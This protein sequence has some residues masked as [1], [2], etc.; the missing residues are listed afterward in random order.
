[1]SFT[2]LYT[3]DYA[4]SYGVVILGTYT[5]NFV[6]NPAFQ[7]GMAG[8]NP[9]NGASISLDSTNTIFGPSSLLVLCPGAVAGEGVTTASGVVTDNSTGSVSC[10][11]NGTGSVTVTAVDNGIV[12][13]TAHVTL[14]QQWTRIVI[15][16]LP[17]SA[18]DSVNLAIETTIA[19]P[20][21]FWLSGVQVE[22]TSP[23]HPYI[24]GNQVGGTWVSG[25]TSGVS[26]QEYENSASA[27]S[28][29][30][31][32][33]N[34]VT[35][36]ST[37]EEFFA[38]PNVSVEHTYSSLV[39]AGS[40]GPASAVTDFSVSDLTD[41]DPAQTYVSWNNAG[42]TMSSS[43]QQSWATFI[44]PAD[45]LVSDG[46]YLYRRGAFAALGWKFESAAE[47]DNAIIAR[48]QAQLLPVLTNI[49][50]PAAPVFDNPRSIHSIIVANR[51][52]FVTNPSFEVS[53]ANWTALGT[54]TLAQDS[55]VTVGDIGE[56]DDTVVTTG[57]YSL[58]ITLNANS[59]GASTS[60]TNLIPGYTYIASAYVKAGAGLDNILMEIGTG[61]TSIQSSGGTGYGASTYNT[62]P[63][64]GFNPASDIPS[65][66]WYRVWCTFTAS[67][68][69]E[70][71]EITCVQAS[72]VSYPTHMWTDAVLVEQG[73]ILNSYFDGS[74]YG[75]GYSWDSVTGSAGLAR[76]YYYEQMAVRQQA[77]N[78][79]LA[80]HTP[81][82]IGYTP[83][84]FSVPPIA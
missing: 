43:W 42:I 24:D 68:D 59:D 76:S 54:A 78:N 27:T 33:S 81:L 46:T 11:L 82:G 35:V 20:A 51:I 1:M 67:S 49:T 48:V 52:N 12:I 44:P 45:Y 31:T 73:D 56:Y 66:I 61:S 21:Q 62:G 41:P 6:I 79:V 18:G 71:L 30:K 83:P 40:S 15:T 4:S 23:A 9:V 74:S 38:V 57:S 28:Q 39:V 5:T 75:D 25:G 80:R 84:V 2:D 58:N 19:N 60:I 13:G 65:N 53:T 64:G 77:V 26:E 69:S 34:V 72:D 16:G 70:E 47:T 37:G 7:A 32:T 55:S 10:Y 36:L 3:D 22:D 63:Y 50:E 8:Y 17:F 29:T 14:T